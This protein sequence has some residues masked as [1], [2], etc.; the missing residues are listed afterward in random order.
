MRI[1]YSFFMLFF[2]VKT[3]SLAQVSGKAVVDSASM[4]VGDQM[5]LRLELSINKSTEL[6]PLDLSGIAADSVFEIL[7]ESKWDTVGNSTDKLRLQKNMLFIAWDS[8]FQS[9]ASIPIAYK[10]GGKTDT[11]YTR[12]ITMKIDFPQV[13]TTL[14]D[15]KPIL[16]EPLKLQDF[17]WY[18]LG[19]LALAFIVVLVLIL[20]KKKNA[21]PP[22]PVPV[23]PLLPHEL[24]LQQLD[25]LAQQR[26]W[27]SGQV[28][29][30]H[31]ALTFIVREYLEKRYGIQALEQTTD[32]ILE[33]LRQRDFDLS[34]S[35]KLGEVLQTADL[36]K[37]A[38]AEPTAEFH[39]RAM[40]VA[41]AFIL[42]TKPAAIVADANNPN[43]VQ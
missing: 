28:K 6:K 36:V 39:E 21:P 1:F 10:Y 29:A 31:S 33:Q 24:A 23:A 19:A 13:D 26:M 15:I 3:V 37:F 8:G 18:I 16:T 4:F 17:I 30:Y 35:Q 40:E 12:K 41:R 7:S 38:K 22:P 20:R 43:N 32:E 11:F 42:K 25:L 9:L 27:Q 5:R 2:L 34:L 14:A